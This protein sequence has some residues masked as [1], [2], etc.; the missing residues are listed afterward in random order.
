MS[1]IWLDFSLNYL[2]RTENPV[3]SIQATTVQ[4]L[5]TVSLIYTGL[6]MFM[7]LNLN[8]YF[9]SQSLIVENINRKRNSWIFWQRIMGETCLR[10]FLRPG[11]YQ[12]LK[13]I[14]L[15]TQRCLGK[16]KT[17]RNCLQEYTRENYTGENESKYSIYLNVAIATSRA[18]PTGSEKYLEC[19]HQHFYCRVRSLT[20]VKPM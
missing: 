13:F 5:A 3:S 18:F 1:S 4:T 2:I 11:E 9:R 20:R 6:L 10:T 14:S 16:F 15:Y 17:G 8:F 12:C 19:M 7:F